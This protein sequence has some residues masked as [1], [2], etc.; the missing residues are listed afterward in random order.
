MSTLDLDSQ[1][2]YQLKTKLNL[3]GELALQ[4]ASMSVLLLYMQLWLLLSKSLVS[5]WQWDLELSSV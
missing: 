3:T 4:S 5:V 2:L 1:S